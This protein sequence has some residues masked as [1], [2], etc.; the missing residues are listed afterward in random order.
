[1]EPRTSEIENQDQEV[2]SWSLPRTSEQLT[3]FV[4]SRLDGLSDV[5]LQV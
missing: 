3:A 5:D 4:M 2:A 1:M